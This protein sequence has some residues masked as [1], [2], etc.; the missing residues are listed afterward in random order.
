MS[1][2]LHSSLP[3][4]QDKMP[5][6]DEQ[7]PTHRGKVVDIQLSADLSPEVIVIDV[8]SPEGNRISTK[9]TCVNVPA[10]LEKGLLH[11]DKVHW[12]TNQTADGSIQIAELSCDRINYYETSQNSNP[13][14]PPTGHGGSSSQP[15][16]SHESVCEGAQ[17][18]SWDVYEDFE[19]DEDWRV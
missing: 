3:Q 12:T 7:P 6:Y 19:S 10:M 4:L 14:N 13:H 8:D 11:L 1:L 17:D 9:D 15:L 2:R 5:T 18:E 16:N